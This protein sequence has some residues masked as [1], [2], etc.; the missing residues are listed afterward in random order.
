MDLST[1][2]KNLENYIKMEDFWKDVELMLNNCIVFNESSTI[3]HQEGKKVLKFVKGLRKKEEEK[4]TPN[5]KEYIKIMDKLIEKDLGG[6]F[7][8]P[9]PDLVE[10][11][12]ELINSPMD[13][14]TLREKMTSIH[15]LND[16]K[17][18]LELIFKNAMK[19]NPLDSIYY[20][21]AENLLNYAQT[22]FKQDDLTI[23]KDKLYPIMEQ[24]MDIMEKEDTSLIFADPVQGIPGYDEIIKHP[25]DF[26][27]MKTKIKEEKYKMWSEYENDYE[28]TFNNSKIFNDKTTIYH[29][30]AVKL[31]RHLQR[32][33][34]KIQ[35]A[36]SQGKEPELIETTRKSISK[37]YSV[38]KSLPF[39]EI[40][41]KLIQDLMK[42]D[43]RKLFHYPV[44]TN[45]LTDYLDVVE[46]P[47]DFISM[48]NKI[49]ENRYK[50]LNEFKKDFELICE[51]SKRY[52]ESQSLY[53]KEAERLLSLGSEFIQESFKIEIEKEEHVEDEEEEEED[54][55]QPRKKTIKKEEGNYCEK[56]ILTIHF[57]QISNFKNSFHCKEI[58]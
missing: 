22:L 38:K 53:F 35:L 44:N 55:D 11:Y 20:Q 24:I 39:D 19:F 36:I 51:N 37:P 46:T 48:K 57:T 25:M 5:Q 26:T 7:L 17:D 33:K 54:D 14:T 49:K 43:K 23:E 34:K 40:L 32:L 31:Q 28:L 21:E 30:E 16:F 18:N 58:L 29:K 2:G 52:N 10:G 47:M 9:V 50:D 1:I 56:V 42:L 27:T 6:I 15:N 8:E 4:L 3:F 13:F 45:Q 41:N 12:Y